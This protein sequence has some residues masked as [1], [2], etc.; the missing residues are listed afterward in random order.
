MAEAFPF[1]FHLV[2]TPTHLFWY[3]G[4]FDLFRPRRNTASLPNRSLLP[5]A[6]APH[7]A[8]QLSHQLLDTLAPH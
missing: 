7:D 8:P 4:S 1:T 3:I 6:T 2:A 5:P